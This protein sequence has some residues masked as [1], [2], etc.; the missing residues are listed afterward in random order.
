VELLTPEQ[1][2]TLDA[3][4]ISEIGLA[5]AVL[6]EN[7][8]SA[9]C[10][11]IERV[12][13]RHHNLL[14]L[15]GG[16]NNGGDASV[17]ARKLFAE[18]WSVRLVLCAS[19]ER[20]TGDALLNWN[21][22]RSTGVPCYVYTGDSATASDGSQCFEFSALLE[23]S[24]L[25]VDGLLG[26]GALGAPRGITKKMIDAVNAA[27]K[28]VVS[29]DVPSGIDALSGAVPGVCISARHTI[30][31]T[32]PKTGMLQ[33]P[34]QEHT[35]QIWVASI[36]IPDH[37]VTRV[38]P[39]AFFISAAQAKIDLPSRRDDA[40]KADSGRVAV[41]AGSR[42]Y[43]GA[44][45][46]C[47]EGS[48][49]AG[50]GLTTLMASERVWDVY[51][52]RLTEIMLFGVDSSDE[53][54]YSEASVLSA[55]QILAEQQSA[56]VGPGITATDDTA[57]FLEILLHELNCSLV[58][59]A[60]ALNILSLHSS[61]RTAFAS[62]VAREQAAITPH[63]GEA[64]RLLGCGVSDV[65]RDRFGAARELAA[66]YSCIAVL[67][68]A[69]TLVALPGGK[70]WV[71][72]TG[73]SALATGGTGDV[74]AGVI[75]GL[76][77]QGASMAEAC[78]AGVYIHGLAADRL[79]DRLRSPGFSALDVAREIPA[80]AGHAREEEQAQAVPAPVMRI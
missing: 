5:G 67:K 70:V 79:L 51:A 66:R 16:G 15:A 58:L 63:T 2:K 27:S 9:A 68:G 50:A 10:R 34:A 48:L 33:Y 45:V 75:A 12:S 60:D 52:T 25:I 20:L 41:F 76:R 38:G 37:M 13:H 8:G 1:M 78:R 14:V 30:T 21:V 69:R 29:L 74:L 71:N 64:A 65:R 42:R 17:V 44:A 46:L 77:A 26:T 80:A 54:T 57:V 36:S 19:P 35:G 7:A 55:G 4:A 43:P 62:F 61:A 56:V 11:L 23:S 73:N 3:L 49:R 47:A 53:G 39:S 32:R 40:H 22:A 72:S 6:M 18:G 24:D 59:D 28:Q 31:F